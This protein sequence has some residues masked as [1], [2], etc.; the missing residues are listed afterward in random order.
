MVDKAPRHGPHLPHGL[1][2]SHSISL[3]AHSYWTDHTL[4]GVKEMLTLPASLL[5]LGADACR[6]AAR[7]SAQA[8]LVPS[9]ISRSAACSTGTNQ[10]TAG[11]QEWSMTRTATCVQQLLCYGC[12]AVCCAYRNSPT[13]VCWERVGAGRLDMCHPRT[14]EFVGV[15]DGKTGPGMWYDLM[16]SG[17]TTQ[18]LAATGMTK[19]GRSAINTSTSISAQASSALNEVFRRVP[20]TG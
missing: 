16:R 15:T 13:R 8:A 5:K 17:C 4:A 10:H 2:I 19:P 6:R 20:S 1:A 12:C 14:L 7:W 11:G 3:N 18:R 9:S